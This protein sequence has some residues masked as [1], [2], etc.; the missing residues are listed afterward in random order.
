MYLSSLFYGQ[1][2]VPK[3]ISYFSKVLCAIHSTITTTCDKNTSYLKIPWLAFVSFPSLLAD[4]GGGLADAHHPTN[5]KFLNFMVFEEIVELM[6][7]EGCHLL[8]SFLT[9][10]PVGQSNLGA[11]QII[12][13]PGSNTQRIFKTRLNLFQ[14]LLFYS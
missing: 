2:G 14:M 12:A 5:Q 8:S 3:Q 13:A 6:S 4:Q 11:H 1:R 7:L 10:V 9:S